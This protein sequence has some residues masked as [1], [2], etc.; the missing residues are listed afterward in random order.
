[1][2]W[3]KRGWWLRIAR[4]TSARSGVGLFCWGRGQCVWEGGSDTAVWLGVLRE[5][6][7]GGNGR[8]PLLAGLFLARETKAA[9]RQAWVLDEVI[10]PMEGR[11]VCPVGLEAE[12]A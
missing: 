1:M 11:V 10:E 6:A 4:P 5:E 8:S 7:L 3:S 12:S 2:R 9:L